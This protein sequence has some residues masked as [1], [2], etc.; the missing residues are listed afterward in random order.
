MTATR[1]DRH[2][3]TAKE[4]QFRLL[5]SSPT[6]ASWSD[7][8]D[9]VILSL[10]RDYTGHGDAILFGKSQDQSV[11]AIRVYRNGQG[12]S[13]YARDLE[14][15][16]EAVERLYR[17]HPPLN[18]RVARATVQRVAVQG[19]NILDLPY[20]PAFSVDALEKQRLKEIERQREWERVVNQFQPIIHEV[21][22]R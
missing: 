5:P 12:Y 8:P 16:G 3:K 6:G 14:R 11:L 20:H 15:V 19:Y 4:R 18:Q 13:V 22:C 21:A 9:A 10:I 2:E 17:L 7:V 1:K